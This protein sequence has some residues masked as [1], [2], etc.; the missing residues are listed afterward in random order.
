MDWLWGFV[1]VG[2]VALWAA[3]ARLYYE[4]G[5][6]AGHEAGYEEGVRHQS[7]RQAARHNR[8]ALG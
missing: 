6:A 1:A 2:A 8:S 4:R 7:Q 3:A 5:H